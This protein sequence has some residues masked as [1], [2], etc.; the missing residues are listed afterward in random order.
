MTV[1]RD[2]GAWVDPA[3]VFDGAAHVG[4]N[5][6]VGHGP[7]ADKNTF[8]G[9]GVQIGAF[10]VIEDGVYI[11]AGVIIDHYC[12]ISRGARIGRETRILYGAQ[13]FDNVSIGHDCI[14][15]GDLVDRTVVGDKVTF[16]G[17][18]AHSHKDPTGD[19]DETEEPSPVIKDGTVV[20]IQALL[21][22]G[23]T[24]GPRA[25]VAAGEIVT[26]D[27]PEDTVLKAG[28]LR[29]L[30]DFRGLIKVRGP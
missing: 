14:I 13:V 24:V 7:R 12:R 17:N 20:G 8:I 2:R 29:P 27:V 19:W 18:T 23:I 5:S 6:C 22:G 26:C 28:Q 11:E 21:I 10:C 16:Q 4:F 30:S 25:Y 3:V 15:G 1:T 9:D